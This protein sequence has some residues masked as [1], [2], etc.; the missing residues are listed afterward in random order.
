VTNDQL[1]AAWKRKLPNVEPTD[2]EL[3]AFALGVEVGQVE[4]A[5][6]VALVEK[7]MVAMNEN[8]DR[9]EKADAEVARLVRKLALER[10]EFKSELAKLKAQPV[11]PVKQA[12]TVENIRAANGIVHSDGNIFFTNIDQLNRAIEGTTT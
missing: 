6:Q 5:T 1:L 10:E 2:Q 8:A 11:Q 4:L 12:L 3:T 9:G 7:C